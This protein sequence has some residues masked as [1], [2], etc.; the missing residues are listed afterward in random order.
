MQERYKT[1]DRTLAR[2]GS[3]GYYSL[4]IA[5]RAGMNL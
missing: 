2:E 3:F 5:V 1:W 4:R